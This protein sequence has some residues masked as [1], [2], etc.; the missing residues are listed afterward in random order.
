MAAPLA[1]SHES[2]TIQMGID[3]D[4]KG[5]KSDVHADDTEG[6]E[7]QTGYI[8]TCSDNGIG[9]LTHCN[10]FEIP[11]DW[12][13]CPSLVSKPEGFMRDELM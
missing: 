10:L 13:M 4:L 5:E 7:E 11:E 1:S 8:L 3:K 2:R 12:R 6:T 9:E